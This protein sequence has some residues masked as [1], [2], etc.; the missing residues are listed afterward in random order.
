MGI[1]GSFQG[2]TDSP[3]PILTNNKP[4]DYCQL[5]GFTCT[6]NQRNIGG[7]GIYSGGVSA[8]PFNNTSVIHSGGNFSNALCITRFNQTFDLTAYNYIDFES[9]G[10]S[11]YYASAELWMGVSNNSQ[12]TSL[13]LTASVSRSIPS[14]KSVSYQYDRVHISNLIGNYYVYVIFRFSRNYGGANDVSAH[15]RNVRLTN[16]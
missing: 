13:S 14:N 5:K 1:I 4:T 2:Y 3:I 8:F 7:N 12:L 11:D 15:V 10:E 9:D 16:V 6:Y